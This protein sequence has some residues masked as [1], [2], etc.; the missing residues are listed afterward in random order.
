L[1]IRAL[2]PIKPLKF[3]LVAAV[4]GALA[5]AALIF[6]FELNQNYH[7]MRLLG[8]VDWLGVK[9]AM[10]ATSVAFHGDRIAYRWISAPTFFDMVLVLVSG[11]QTGLIGACIGGLLA[12]VKRKPV[13]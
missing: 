12:L 5:S 7:A 6:L 4:L 8:T 9:L 10:M 11:L 2:T 13:A 1:E 3:A